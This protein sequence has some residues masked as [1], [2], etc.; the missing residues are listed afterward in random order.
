MAKPT[1]PQVEQQ[2]LMCALQARSP[3]IR[4]EILSET[5]VED[6]GTEEGVLVRKRINTLF[7]G[8]KKLGDATTFSAD[9]ALTKAAS[10]WIRGTAGMRTTAAAFRMEDVRRNIQTLKMHRNVRQLYQAQQEINDIAGGELDEEGI[11][12]IGSIMEGALVGIR[13][14]FDRQ[15]LLH[16]GRRQSNE[17][18]RII[19]DK[20]LTFDPKSFISTGQR[21]LDEHLYG[22]EK[23][24]LVTISAPRGGGKSTMAMVMAINQ[25]LDANLNVCFVS[26]EMTKEEVFK[27]VL[28]NISGVE[29]G[30]VRYSKGMTEE[31][32][33][34]VTKAFQRFHRHGH[35]SDCSFTIWDVK[36]PFFTP[37][38]M[39][40][41]LAPF[42]YDVIYVDY[43][44][45]FHA[46]NMD[47]WKM[48]LE[49]SR[50]LKSMAKR[51]NCVI[52][53]ITQLSEEERVKYGKGIEENTDYWG[54]WRWREDEEQ[55]SG[56]GEFRLDKARHAARRRIPMEFFL[57]VMNITTSLSAAPAVSEKKVAG[58][59]SN[60]SGA[61]K[62]PQSSW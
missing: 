23:G 15:P 25:F 34:N 12:R 41:S 21:G 57:N 44:T 60:E 28:S 32:R 2:L 8:G 40:A 13:E 56:R 51:L 26:M 24:N 33:A 43:L 18:A 6:Y 37:M 3:R 54:W 59:L 31:E 62:D 52:V 17:E 10:A 55:E 47:T 38:K 19:L 11:E 45:L 20:I 46:N 50:Y 4:G 61:W 48:Q 9:P 42:M 49:Y 1:N 22:W 36:D 29:H 30:T 58:V 39:E 27:R 5:S 35:N 7:D 16:L 53:V 14:G